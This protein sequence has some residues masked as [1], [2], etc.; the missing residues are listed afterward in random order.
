MNFLSKKVL[1]FQKKKLVSAE[2]T[3]KKYITEME[4]LEKIENIDNSKELENHKKMIKIWTENI[5][6]IK[7]E[8]KK[9]ES[10]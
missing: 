2:E 1:D 6:K 9:I 8:I 3:L 4:K 5:E 10:R 7:K